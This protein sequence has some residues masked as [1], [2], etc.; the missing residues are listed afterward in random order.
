MP[1]ILERE[2]ACSGLYQ[3]EEAGVESVVDIDLLVKEP[4]CDAI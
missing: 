4:G 1:Q 3:V 2:H